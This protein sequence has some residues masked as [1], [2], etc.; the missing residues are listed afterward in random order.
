MIV[1]NQTFLDVID[2]IKSISYV[3]AVS[4]RIKT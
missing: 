3:A 4:D 2:E 1:M